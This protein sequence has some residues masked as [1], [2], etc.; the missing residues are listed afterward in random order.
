VSASC[1][2]S[3]EDFSNVSVFLH[4]DDSKLIFFIA[5]DEESLLVIQENT[6][7]RWPVSVHVGGGKI[8]V[9]FPVDLKVMFSMFFIKI[10]I[11]LE[12]KQN[13]KFLLT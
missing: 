5:P 10:R 4:G 1:A 11:Q 12:Q 2:E 7:A 6:S 8:F 13:L 3:S 9:S